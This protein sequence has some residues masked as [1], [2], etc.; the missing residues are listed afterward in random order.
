MLSYIIKRI[1][2]LIP[3]LFV[4]SVVV[5]LVVYMIP[6][7]PATAL[8]GMEAT[9]EAIADLNA[10]LGFDR[11]F[12][13]QYADWF[14]NMLH[15]DWGQSYFLQT[16]VLDAIGEYFVPTFSLAVFAQLISLVI[17]VPMGILA[18][19]KRGTSVDIITVSISLL[20]IAIPGFL[21]SM[22]LMLFFGVHLKWLPVAGYVQMSQ[23]TV[24]TSPVSASACL[25]AGG[26]PGC[27]YYPH[28][29]I[30]YAG[31]SLYELHTHSPGKGAEGIC[32]G[33]GLR[34]EKRGSHHTDRCRPV[35]W[36]PCNR[37]HRDRNPVQHTGTGHA[38]HDFYYAP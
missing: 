37:N 6:G 20:G 14:I 36:Q 16:T 27:L 5:F 19:Y 33:P 18:A 31:C 24:G 22:F 28:V 32:R 30:R 25:V 38:Y 3:T 17:A 11:P 15:G 9:P 8:L 23:G 12:F 1:L 4:V 34:P 21:L 35:L 2:S 13:V 29:P 26:C 10:Q 7:G